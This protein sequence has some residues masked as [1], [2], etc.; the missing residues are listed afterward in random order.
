MAPGGASPPGPPRSHPPLRPVISEP[1]RGGGEAAAAGRS[2]IAAPAPLQPPGGPRR[3]LSLGPGPELGPARE[4]RRYAGT[5][6]RLVPRPGA[7]G[8]KVSGEGRAGRETRWQRGGRGSPDAV[9]PALLHPSSG[10]SRALCGRP[11]LM[12]LPEAPSTSR[13]CGVGKGGEVDLMWGPPLPF[14]WLP[15][16]LKVGP[17]RK[18]PQDGPPPR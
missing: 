8:A 14:S 15:E 2:T 17:R 13:R 16:S 4:S 18:G 5:A 12:G 9:A 1:A 11:A 10:S 3:S 7:E 6:A